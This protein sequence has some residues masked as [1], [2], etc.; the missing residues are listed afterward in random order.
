MKKGILLLIPLNFI[1]FL[2]TCNLE[3]QKQPA[4]ENQY[5]I[6]PK[7]ALLTPN[8]GQFHIDGSTKILVGEEE[9]WKNVAVFLQ[10]KLKTAS[11]IEIQLGPIASESNVIAFQK[12]ES[13]QEEEGYTLSRQPGTN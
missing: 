1:L 10:Q 7:P 6:I 3:S 9:A 12:D 8:Q 13:I 4:I 2:T 11:G 5:A